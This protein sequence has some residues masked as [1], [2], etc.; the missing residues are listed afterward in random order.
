M[1]VGSGRWRWWR[2]IGKVGL[3]SKVGRC[4]C[5]EVRMLEETA[6]LVSY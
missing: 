5:D 6:V 1:V 2:L 4:A 3:V